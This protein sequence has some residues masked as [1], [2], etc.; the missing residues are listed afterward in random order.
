Q[1]EARPG[2]WH[3]LLT[4]AALVGAVTALLLGLGAA[5]LTGLLGASSGLAIALGVVV[6]LVA[7]AAEIAYIGRASVWQRG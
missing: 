3:L 1:T 6:A 2:R 4:A 7:F 5:L